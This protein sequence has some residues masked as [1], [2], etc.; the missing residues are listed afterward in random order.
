MRG[1][2]GVWLRAL[3]K[4]IGCDPRTVPPLYVPMMEPFGESQSL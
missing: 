2:R 3:N 4:R 1:I